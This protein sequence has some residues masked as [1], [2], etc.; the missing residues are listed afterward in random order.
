[1]TLVNDH[2]PD[3]WIT[4]TMGE[5]SDVVGGGTPKT[6]IPGNFDDAEG[7][8][9]LTPADLT[10]HRAKTISHGRRFLTDQGLKASAAKYMPAGT[11]LFSS[12]APIGYVAIAANPVTTNQGFRS[13]VPSERLDP[14]Y[15]YHYLRSIKELAEQ[16]ASGTTFNELSG[17]KAKTLPIP[18][19]PVDEQR[20][21]AD[22][23]D[24]IDAR[25]ASIVDRL[26]AT[27]AIVGRLR[28]AVLAAACS[29]RLTA[30]WRQEHP[31]ATAGTV[32]SSPTSAEVAL[33]VPATWARCTL[34]EIATSITSGPRDWSPY[35]NRGSSTFVMAQNV[36]PGRLD[37]SFHQAIDPPADD[38]GRRRCQIE[39][40]DVLVTIVGANTGDVAPVLEDRAKHFVCQSVALLR[41]PDGEYAPYLSHWF[42]S[43]EH[44]RRYFEECMYG[45]GRP[46]LSFEQLRKA[47]IAI[48]PAAERREIVTRVAA[49]VNIADR[50]DASV[51]AAEATLDAASRASMFKAFRGELMPPEPDQGAARNGDQGLG[52][53][54]AGTAGG[55]SAI[56]GARLGPAGD[57]PVLSDAEV[58]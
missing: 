39:V 54:A 49:A 20:R 31:D 7:H 57:Q 46:H 2:L 48:P 44:G 53:A 1:L 37:W 4:T 47:P 28:A 34:E 29:G 19:P 38:P 23:L 55:P 16:M 42:N 5:V 40:G 33:D 11:I 26:G 17:S 43:V 30:D 32:P 15:A 21:I 10:G 25:Q 35:Y 3:G 41:P 18:L 8:P 52:A 50:L 14:N 56:T 12:R 45:A 6:T 58:S 24:K 27:R 9:W 13:F 51:S 22:W 36:R